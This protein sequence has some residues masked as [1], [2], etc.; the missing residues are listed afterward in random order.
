MSKQYLLSHITDLANIDDADVPEFI[1]TLP[2]LIDGLKLASRAAE[3]EGVRLDVVLPNVK[4][5]PD[6]KSD[7]IVR[8]EG[9]A[10]SYSGDAVA[11]AARALVK[12]C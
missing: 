12:P 7:F 5:V 11:A 6:L 2:V 10:I 8:A 3:A 1:R 4:F 9:H